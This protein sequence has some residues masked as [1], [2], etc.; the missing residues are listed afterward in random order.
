MKMNMDP[1]PEEKKKNANGDL[2]LS[3]LITITKMKMRNQD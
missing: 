1:N 2:I 3:N